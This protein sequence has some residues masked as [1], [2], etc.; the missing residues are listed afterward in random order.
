MNGGVIN[1]VNEIDFADPNL[2]KTLTT[3]NIGWQSQTTD[4]TICPLGFYKGL[5]TDSNC[6]R[7]G[8][9]KF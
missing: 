2:A 6:Y 7:E 8:I 1:A 4:I 9:T 5:T 3:N